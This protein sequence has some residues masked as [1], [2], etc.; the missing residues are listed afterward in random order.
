MVRVHLA[1]GICPFT[2][3]ESFMN[4]RVL[5]MSERQ[6]A[7]HAGCPIARCG[8]AVPAAMNGLAI[9]AAGGGGGR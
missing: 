4:A 7:D 9:G 8:L 3:L 5:R 2:A 6:A 1:A